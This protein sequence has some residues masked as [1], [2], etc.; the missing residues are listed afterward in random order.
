MARDVLP[1]D[2]R[3]VHEASH[4]QRE[5]AQ[6][7]DVERLAREVQQQQR[8]GDRERDADADDDQAPEASQEHQDHEERQRRPDER[9][10]LERGERRPDVLRLVEADPERDPRGHA[11]QPR[12]RGPERVDDLDGVGAGLAGDVEQDAGL[13]V[14]VYDL[15]LLRRCV[16]HLRHIADA[17]RHAPSGRHDHV[18]DRRGALQERRHVQLVAQFGVVEGPGRQ[19]RVVLGDGALHVL[20]RQPDGGQF[21]R[22]DVDVDLAHEPAVHERLRDAGDP[23]QL[24][25]DRL[26]GQG[27]ELPGVQ[28]AAAHHDLG[29]RDVGDVE[30][31]D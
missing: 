11:G 26:G 15:G 19:Q 29:H 13:S 14:H 2:D 27:I 16:A 4:R 6:R 8:G 10:A 31:Q 22:I 25:L 5:A 17:H 3:V 7:E 23:L 21:V 9:F 28:V 1:H 20:Q 18:L 24:R 30:L 12:Q